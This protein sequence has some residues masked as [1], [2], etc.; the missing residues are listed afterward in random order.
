MSLQSGKLPHR[1]LRKMIGYRGAKDE[2][3]ILGPRIGE[4]AAVVDLGK[5]VLILKTDPISYATEEIGWYAVNINANDIATMGARP[6]WLQICLLLP[7]G[8]S[9]KDVEKIFRQVDIACK[10][11]G[12]AVTG[13]HTEVNPWL[14]RP[15]IV[16]DIQ[17]ICRK[18]DLVL[19][20][21]A[22]VG[23]AIVL[24]KGAGIE[25]TATLVR[26]KRAH[27]LGRFSK[28]FIRRAANYLYDPGIS[29]VNE[30]LLGA[31]LG[32]TSM[33]DPTEGGILVGLYEVAEASNKGFLVYAD[34][35]IVRKETEALCEFFGLDPLG[36][37]GSGSLL[38]ALPKRKVD[39]YL[40]A[41]R[42]EG[43]KGSE[44]GEI[45]SRGYGRK[46]VR[47]GKKE[48]LRFSQRDEILK[49]L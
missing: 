38:V 49:V 33:H 44:I 41:L 31:K 26:E 47:D 11:L 45:K 2:S 24:T 29:V 5:E 10:S 37:L 19:T 30:A 25:G 39:A 7:P 23:N 20:S 48:P 17:G 46:I 15:I 28:A 43:I 14:D 32:A 1:L 12:I 8:M 4:D 18:E 35:I 13:G 21:G 16:G 40:D 42:E 3:V 34:E 6:K 27:L 36:L 22:K 9:P